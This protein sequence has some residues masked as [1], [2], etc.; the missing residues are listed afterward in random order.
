MRIK[1][2][3]LFRLTKIIDIGYVVIIYFIIGVSLAKLTDMI[4]GT[5]DSEAEQKKSFIRLC[6]EIIGLIWF[7][8]IVFY[9][10]RNVVEWIPSPLHGHYGYDHYRLKEL[11]GA[12]ILGATYVFF[13][14]NLR[15]KLVD[16]KARIMI[17]GDVVDSL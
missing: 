16:L 6:A 5:Y 7:N 12:A 15:N 3:A 10:A 4:F 14:T 2:E 13:Q 8:L 1:K 11:S 17:S 9:V